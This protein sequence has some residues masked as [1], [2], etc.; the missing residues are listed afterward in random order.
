[1]HDNLLI[2]FLLVVGVV[3]LFLRSIAG[4][5]VV[6]VVIPLALL[7]AFIGLYALGLPANLI[8]MGAIDFGI[9]VDGAVVLVE[10]VIHA[11]R[12]E[13]PDDRR[14]VLR[15]VVRSAVDVGRPTF[16][17]M[18]IIIAAL[19]PV[20]TLQSRRRTDLPA[21]RA[22]LLLRADR[23]AGVRADAGAGAVRGAVPAAATREL[24][25]PAWIERLRAAYRRVARHG[26]SSAAP[27]VIA[28]AFVL[29][30]ARR[31]LT[32]T[33]LGTEFLPEL[34]EGDI[35]LFVEMPP[36]IALE[37]GQ[38]ILLD[39]RRRMLAFPEVAQDPERARPPRGRHRQ[40]RRQHERDVH[41]PEAAREWRPGYDKKRLIDEMRASLT[42]IPGVRYNFSQP[43][44][45]NVEEAVSGVR[46]KVVLKIFGT[47]LA[48]MRTT[49]EQAKEALKTV[50]GIVDLDLYR[51]VS[52]PQLQVRF[53]RQALARAGIADRGRAA[54][55][56]DRA[57]R[58]RGDHHVGGRA[59]GAGAR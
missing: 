5:L 49:L 7:V 39:V 18:P 35:Q 26:C 33:R 10:N 50:P 16:Y 9:L 13:Q 22:H 54:H 55:A 6:A 48:R 59:S 15:L 28:A 47:D 19:M 25:E 8:S 14:G 57:R 11:L 24:E 45:D 53:D 41:P 1:M 51:D 31:V 2:G 23:R 32:V 46:G 38:D 40:R 58:A 21:A 3:W 52:M 12:H 17:A 44:K 56:R 37:K 34:D 4:S 36:S 27:L 43:M 42:E 30:A 29:L 20:F